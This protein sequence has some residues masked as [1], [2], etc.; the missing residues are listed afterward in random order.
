MFDHLGD[1]YR[2][3]GKMAEA[4]NYWQKSLALEPNAKVREKIEAGKQQVTKS[5]VPPADKR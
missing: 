3:L 2:A 4:M 1:T 5:N